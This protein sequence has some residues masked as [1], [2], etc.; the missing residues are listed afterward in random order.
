MKGKDGYEIPNYGRYRFYSDVFGTPDTF[1]TYHKPGQTT[2]ELGFAPGDH[3]YSGLVTFRHSIGDDGYVWLDF[4]TSRRKDSKGYQSNIV[5]FGKF[6]RLSIVK[7][8]L[9]FSLGSSYWHNGILKLTIKDITLQ[10]AN[11]M[12][13]N[14]IGELTLDE[15]PQK[16]SFFLG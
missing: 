8:P 14:P 12:A 16:K 11:E 7:G 1:I 15:L 3:K 10:K 4:E 9:R 13:E 5:D 2:S 6:R